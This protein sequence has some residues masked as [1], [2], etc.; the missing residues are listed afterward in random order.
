MLRLES[1]KCWKR[2]K[3]KQTRVPRRKSG[4]Y[5]VT[6][7]LHQAHPHHTLHF[8]PRLHRII[9]SCSCSPEW[10]CAEACI[11]Q[12]PAEPLLI[13]WCHTLGYCISFVCVCT[14]PFIAKGTLVASCIISFSH[15]S[16]FEKK[17]Y[18]RV[19]ASCRYKILPKWSYCPLSRCSYVLDLQ[20]PFLAQS[21]H[22]FG[23]RLCVSLQENIACAHTSQPIY[24]GN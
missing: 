5:P 1:S 21:R 16:P 23:P 2:R 6:F 19:S 8:T 20:E 3:R 18:G 15:H 14:F 11:S 24:H 10:R 9:R 17:V 22:L 4:Q 12:L 13:M 7:I